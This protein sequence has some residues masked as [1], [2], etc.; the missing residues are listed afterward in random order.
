MQLN[1]C[2]S[3]RCLNSDCKFC[4]G[5]NLFWLRRIVAVIKLSRIMVL[6]PNRKRWLCSGFSAI[7]SISA[8]WWF[9]RKNT[10]RSAVALDKCGWPIYTAAQWQWATYYKLLTVKQ[11]V[12]VTEQFNGA[13][14]YDI[15]SSTR[16]SNQADQIRNIYTVDLH[17][18]THSTCAV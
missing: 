14:S 3:M 18:F 15:H 9:G 13:E 17:S 10:G 12:R 6:I 8:L 7:D 1:Y 2:V 5:S 16:S 4:S 11:T